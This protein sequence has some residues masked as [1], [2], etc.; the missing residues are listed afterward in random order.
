MAAGCGQ[1]FWAWDCWPLDLRDQSR[2]KRRLDV[3]RH[4][5]PR[6]LADKKTPCTFGNCGLLYGAIGEHRVVSIAAG[7]TFFALLAI[8]PAVAALVSIYGLFADPVTLQSDLNDLSSLLPGGAIEVVGDQL[9]RVLSQGRSALGATFAIS[10]AISLWSANAGM[11]ALFDALNIVYESKES[12]GFFRLNATS[13]V[14]TAGG[15]MLSVVAIA[16]I[17]ILPVALDYIGLKAISGSLLNIG[18][19]PALFVL[20]ALAFT[21]IYRFGP[22]RQH[23]QW[24]WITWGIAS[25][26]IVWIAVSILFSWYAAN[27]GSYNKTYGS[28]GAVIGFMTWIWISS[29][30]ILGGAEIDALL[31]R[32]DRG[33][34]K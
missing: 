28:L 9:Q 32:L 25:A 4:P 3:E 22:D 24:H 1:L 5:R 27:F 12:R 18:R 23:A 11:K 2:E 26:T 13:L 16:A 21:V 19:W 17:I 7:V 6:S 15:L 14:F 20:I 8:F 30:V 31:E 29:M 10:L 33:S 34:A